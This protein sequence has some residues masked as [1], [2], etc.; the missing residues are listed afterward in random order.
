MSDDSSLQLSSIVGAKPAFMNKHG[1]R[2]IEKVFQ[3]SF[4]RTFESSFHREGRP[5][6]FLHMRK[7]E[8]KIS[9]QMIT[10]IKPNVTLFF[11][12]WKCGHRRARRFAFLAQ[13][14]NELAVS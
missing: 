8:W 5:A 13:R 2:T 4:D 9:V 1:V 3:A 11:H 6:L 14:R 10:R 7:S 12:A